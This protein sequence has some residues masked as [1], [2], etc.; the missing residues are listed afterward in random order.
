MKN[1]KL[2]H[3]IHGWL[4]KIQEN[5]DNFNARTDVTNDDKIEFITHQYHLVMLIYR[6]LNSQV[7]FVGAKKPTLV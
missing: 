6:A 1:E 2:N 7:I 4:E 3:H 5:I